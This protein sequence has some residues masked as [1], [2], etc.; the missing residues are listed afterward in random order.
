MR[1]QWG[2]A[3]AEK[4]TVLLNEGDLRFGVRRS[5]ENGFFAP[6]DV[7]SMT[8]VGGPS[9]LVVV[10]IND[11]PLSAFSPLSPAQ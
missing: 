6:K 10:G 5:R 8:L 9:L 1:P 3:D 2:R 11:A 7:R 4:G